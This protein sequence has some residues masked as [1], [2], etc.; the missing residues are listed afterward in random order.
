MSM[1]PILE[2]RR[3]Y[4]ELQEVECT[5]QLVQTSLLKCC[6]VGEAS[7]DR[8]W[9]SDCCCHE[10]EQIDIQRYS[11]RLTMDFERHPDPLELANELVEKICLPKKKG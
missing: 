2:L 3:L 6:T 11:A 1:V 7:L 10:H 4:R 8:L 9:I 5:T